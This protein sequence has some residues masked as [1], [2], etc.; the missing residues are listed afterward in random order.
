MEMFQSTQKQLVGRLVSDPAL[1]QRVERLMGML[2]PR[3]VYG[4]VGQLSL[5]GSLMRLRRERP[6]R[7]QMK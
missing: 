5:A 6:R 4:A 2:S 1:K 7:E 3:A